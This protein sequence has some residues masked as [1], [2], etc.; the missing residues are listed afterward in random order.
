[1]HLGGAAAQ[2]GG[3]FERGAGVLARVGGN[4]FAADWVQEGRRGA[5]ILSWRAG[6][7]ALVVPGEQ[8]QH[9]LPAIALVFD[10][11]LERGQRRLL[12]QRRVRG[13]AAANV[14]EEGGDARVVGDLGKE[15]ADLSV[16]VFSGLD[17]AEELQNQFAAKEDGGVG[18]LGRAGAGGERAAAPGGGEGGG[19]VAGEGGGGPRCG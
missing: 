1:M 6:C 16:G 14:S 3:S 13:A 15:A 11:T 12:R 2:Q 4:R 8:L 10:Q 5:G 17:S 18:L 19:C 7:G 9:V